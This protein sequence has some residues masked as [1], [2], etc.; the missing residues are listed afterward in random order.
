MS[1]HKLLQLTSII[2]FM[3]KSVAFFAKKLLNKEI[4]KNRCDEASFSNFSDQIL[5]QHDNHYFPR[6]RLRQEYPKQNQSKYR[7]EIEEYIFDQGGTR[8]ALRHRHQ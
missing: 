6:S 8:L 7:S 1:C 5:S 4:I 3:S 2:D